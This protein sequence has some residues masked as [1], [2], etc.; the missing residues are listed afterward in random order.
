MKQSVLYRLSSTLS[1]PAMSASAIKANINLDNNPYFSIRVTSDSI[2]S[3]L[4]LHSYEEQMLYDNL[5]EVIKYLNFGISLIEKG[6]L[7][8]YVRYGTRDFTISD[9]HKELEK[10]KT[11]ESIFSF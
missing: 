3:S 8:L 6:E 5:D 9:I 7:V 2:G 1:S 4:I 11:T 10:F